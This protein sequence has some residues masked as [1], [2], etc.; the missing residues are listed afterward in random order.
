MINNI[1]IEKQM[2]IGTIK[3]KINEL[4]SRRDYIMSPDFKDQEFE[5]YGEYTR[6]QEI[7]SL[8]IEIHKL[9]RRILNIQKEIQELINICDKSIVLRFRAYLMDH[10]INCNSY[11]FE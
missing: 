4:E 2:I 5:E 6:L 1:L 8:N 9:K 7:I 11:Q 10:H 3:N